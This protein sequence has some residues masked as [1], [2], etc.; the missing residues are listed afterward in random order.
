MS[1]ALLPGITPAEVAS[2]ASLLRTADSCVVKASEHTQ[3]VT[4]A[5]LAA[6]VARVDA[7]ESARLIGPWES[8]DVPDRLVAETE[9]PEVGEVLSRK[10]WPGIGAAE[11]VLANGMRVALKKTDFLNDQVLVSAFAAGGLSEEDPLVYPS[12]MCASMV[13]AE[14]RA[15]AAWGGAS[16]RS[17]MTLRTIPPPHNPSSSHHATHTTRAHSARHTAL[18]SSPSTGGAVR[19]SPRH[20]RRGP[21]RRP[22]A[23]LGGP[24]GVLADHLGRPEPR[25]SGGCAADGVPALH[26]G[27]GARGRG[28]G[29]HSPD[30]HVRCE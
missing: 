12:A 3:S 10:A 14:A 11:I 18:L 26:A 17:R 21:R 20:P 7:A 13:A 27:A 1:K 23:R 22:R 8:G 2:C 9:E 5:D 29:A 6:A 28:R 15:F 4:A 25:P 24:A 16:A 19:P 30:D